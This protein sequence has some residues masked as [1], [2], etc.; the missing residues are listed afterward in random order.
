[1]S[2][3]KFMLLHIKRELH[4]GLTMLCP[5]RHT[6]KRYELRK[7]ARQEVGTLQ[8]DFGFHYLEGVGGTQVLISPGPHG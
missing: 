6:L 1:M 7:Q 2:F 8:S 3:Y 5:I 4:T